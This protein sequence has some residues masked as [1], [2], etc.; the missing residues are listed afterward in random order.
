MRYVFSKHICSQ[1]SSHNLQE[2]VNRACNLSRTANEET[3]MLIDDAPWG[4]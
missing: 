2:M 1:G 4:I 3:K